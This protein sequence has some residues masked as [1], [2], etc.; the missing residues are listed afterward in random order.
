METKANIVPQEKL[1]NVLNCLTLNLEWKREKIKAYW[2]FY[3]STS[4]RDV[5]HLM[6]N[7]L[8]VVFGTAK[9]TFYTGGKILKCSI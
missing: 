1:K 8:A 5:M 7:Q 9:I 6:G 2:E 3:A 4:M